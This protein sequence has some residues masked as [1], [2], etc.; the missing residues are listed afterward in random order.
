MSARFP[1]SR[2][3]L[4]FALLLTAAATLYKV[5]AFSRQRQAADQALRVVTDG[6]RPFTME[7]MP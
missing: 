4:G 6:L 7:S 1:L 5:V 2:R 3:W